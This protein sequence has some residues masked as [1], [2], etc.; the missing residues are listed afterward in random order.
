M[1][2]CSWGLI[3]Y[4]ETAL[5]VDPDTNDIQSQYLISSVIAHEI[6]H[7]WFGNMVTMAE[8]QE[9]WLNEGFASY[10]ENLGARV[11]GREGGCAAGWGRARHDPA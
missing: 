3:T 9:L 5:L 4:R 6:S 10:F 2:A 11:G 8:W 7:Q 1:R